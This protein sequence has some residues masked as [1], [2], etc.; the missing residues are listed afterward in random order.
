MKDRAYPTVSNTGETVIGGNILMTAEEWDS[1]DVERLIDAKA[2]NIAQSFRA[3]LL[4][5]LK[6]RR[7]AQAT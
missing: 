3:L 1:A 2:A 5:G 7:S 6:K 4:E